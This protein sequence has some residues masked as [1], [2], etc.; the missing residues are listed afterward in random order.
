MEP[1]IITCGTTQL[2]SSRSIRSKIVLFHTTNYHLV[3]PFPHLLAFRHINGWEKGIANPN[4]H[5]WPVLFPQL[6]QI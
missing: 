4:V 5:L 6:I 2:T 1:L 3:I